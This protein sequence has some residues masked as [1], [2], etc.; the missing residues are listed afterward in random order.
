LGDPTPLSV[1]RR[2]VAYIQDD[3]EDVV[4]LNIK[5]P[6]K[7]MAN[8]HVS[9]LDPGRVRSMTIVGSKK[10]VIYDD[11]AENKIAI[12]DK[13]IERMAV[14]GENMDYDNQ[15]FQTFNLRSGD[16]LFPKID[17]KEPLKVEIDHFIDCIEN[18]TQCL[19]GIDHAQKVV[20]ILSSEE[21]AT[22]EHDNKNAAVVAGFPVN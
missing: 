6:N 15:H 20:E 11:T 19:T 5:Y 13:G 18:G 16:L 21:Q 1:I 3:I 10:M 7:I 14:L 4:F 9:W 2:G 12:Y 22:S 8:I 17:F